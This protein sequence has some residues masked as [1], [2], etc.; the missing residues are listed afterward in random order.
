MTEKM[1]PDKATSEGTAR[2]ASRFPGHQPAGFFRSAQGNTVSSLGI[3][4]YLGGLDEASDRNY[5]EA[6]LAA[7]RG[8]INFIDAA[9]NYR[10]QRSERCIGE[11]LGRMAGAGEIRR[12]EVVVCT[13]AGFLVPDAV[14][15]GVLRPSDIVGGMHCMATAFLEDQIGRSRGNLGLETIDVFYLHNPETQLEQ[16][17]EDEFYERIRRA[18]EKLEELAARGWIANYG[19]ATWSGFRKPAGSAGALSLARMAGIA[20]DVA[21]ESHRFRYI[22]LPFN[23][24]MPEAFTQRTARVDGSPESVL[25]LAAE[26]GITVVASA[27][28]LQSRLASGL[29]EE[30]GKRLPG[31]ETDAQRAIQF[32][33]S[34]PGITVALVG[35]SSAAHVAE[36]LGI[37]RVRAAAPE[38]YMEIFR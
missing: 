9:I 38:D 35:M 6:L 1:I 34:T 12:D 21:G 23:L 32:T 19:A 3:G 27:T 20:R 15:L 31:P 17:P 24:G 22:Q 7:V 5:V 2:F 37:A 8:G 14:P 11:A 10:H 4:T 26:L 28:L 29:P 30:I 25:D 13:K 33:R 18:F 16:L 36:N